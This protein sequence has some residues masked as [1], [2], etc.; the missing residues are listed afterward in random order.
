MKLSNISELKCKKQ[1]G[2]TNHI[3]VRFGVRTRGQGA[4]KWTNGGNLWTPTTQPFQRLRLIPYRRRKHLIFRCCNPI[5]AS[6]NRCPPICRR[7][8]DFPLNYLYLRFSRHCR[9]LGQVSMTGC[10]CRLVGHQPPAA[11]IQVTRL[12]RRMEVPGSVNCVQNKYKVN[13][14]F[15][16]IS[17]RIIIG[18]RLPVGL[19]IPSSV[20]PAVINLQVRAL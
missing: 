11:A 16:S 13:W 7:P 6:P 20:C 19:G 12:R 3:K 10:R 1:Y 4:T 2:N 5:L 17:L 15:T 8:I 18:I 9:L 14:H